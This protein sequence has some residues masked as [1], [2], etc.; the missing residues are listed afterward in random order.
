MHFFG[1][2][3]RRAREAAGM[4]Q[5]ELG[6]LVPC[7]KATVSR[8][9]AGLT[10]PDEAFAR[11]CDAAFPHLDGW[12]TRFLRNSNGWTEAIPLWFASWIDVE[13][14]ASLLRMWEPA[15]IPGLL[16]TKDYAREIFRSWRADSDEAVDAK[17]AARLDRQAIL[18]SDGPPLIHLL[19]GESVLHR[20][21]GNPAAMAAQLTHLLSQAECSN[22]TVQ[23]VPSTAGIYAMSG[24]LWEA[25]TPSGHVVHLDDVIQGT[26]STE[27]NIVDHAVRILDA[28]RGDALPRAQ[29]LDVIA[30]V[31][32]QW[33]TAARHG[34]PQVTAALTAAPA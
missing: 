12:F 21:V 17:V 27:P 14:I 15:V 29:S 6:D 33:E 8:I 19:L 1:S 26:T 10:Q 9:E 25:H 4:S 31:K 7:D 11:A 16:Q 24:S 20:Q 22:I 23:V 3:V 28:L 5:S 34:A 18:R 2:E 30:E 13:R 32:A